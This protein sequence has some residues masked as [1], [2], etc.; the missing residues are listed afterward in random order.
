MQKAIDELL[1][2]LMRAFGR[3]RRGARR[4]KIGFRRT[5]PRKS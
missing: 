3:R 1:T 5:P 2:Q 4:P